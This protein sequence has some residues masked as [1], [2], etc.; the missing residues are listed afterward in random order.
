MFVL[1]ISV[2]PSAVG[3][4]KAELTKSL[5]TV[6]SS[7]RAEALARGLGFRTY[8]ALLAGSRSPEPPVA[9]VTGSHFVDYLRERGFEAEPTVLY[10]AGAKAIIVG[11][12]ETMPKLSIHGLGFG[13]PRRNPDGSW[14]SS[15]QR[16]A[17]FLERREACLHQRSAEAF[18]RSLALLS[19]VTATKTIRAGTGSYRLKHI[20]ENYVCF[21]PDGAKLGPDYVPNGMLIAAAV[22]MGFKYKAHV[23]DLGYD[24]LNASFNMSKAIIDDLDAEAR[25]HFY[26]NR[27]RNRRL[28]PVISRL[29]A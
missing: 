5:P 12:L 3:Q 11:L 7:H 22:H 21:Y 20:A 19:R 10:L 24:T 1:Q 26:S 25:P 2:T 13:R 18:L 27:V 6:K 14:Q 16:V 17:E 9:I 29:S 23:D 28:A 8:A 15:E 4:I